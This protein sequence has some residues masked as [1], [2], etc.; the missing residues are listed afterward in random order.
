VR[1]SVRFTASREAEREKESGRE[2]R[3]SERSKCLVNHGSVES[4]SAV[5]RSFGSFLKQRLRNASSS[6]EQRS[7][8]GGPSGSSTMRNMADIATRPA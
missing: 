7:G 4:S 8:M 3:T 6:D 1:H 2:R 5:G